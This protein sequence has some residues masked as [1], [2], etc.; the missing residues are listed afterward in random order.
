MSKKL[1]MSLATPEGIV[2]RGE[3]ESVRF[4]GAKGNFMVLPMHAPLISLLNAGKIIY[5]QEGKT[6]DLMIQGGFVE[7]KKDVVTA[8]VEL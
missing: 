5:T 6:M 3:V 2:F 7:I 8:C 4:P 1:D